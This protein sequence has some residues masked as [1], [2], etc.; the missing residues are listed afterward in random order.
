M[1][2]AHFE[3]KKKEPEVMFFKASGN[4]AQTMNFEAKKKN[5]IK[6]KINKNFKLGVEN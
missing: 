2:I 4:K 3:F 5:I 1:Y 6:F